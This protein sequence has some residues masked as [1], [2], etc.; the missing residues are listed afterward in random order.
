MSV[1]HAIVDLYEAYLAIGVM[2]MASTCIYI[3]SE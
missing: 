3:A 2:K 1:I